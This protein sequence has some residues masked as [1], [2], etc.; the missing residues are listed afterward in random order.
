MAKK[1]LNGYKIAELG[2]HFVLEFV[3]PSVVKGSDSP[4]SELAA[5]DAYSLNHGGL[6]D[7]QNSA[8]AMLF[9]KSNSKVTFS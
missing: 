7:G 4:G 2:V 5:S 1:A 8:K 9:M 3:N 6:A